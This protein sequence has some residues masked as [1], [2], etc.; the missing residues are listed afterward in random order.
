M[1]DRKSIYGW[2]LLLA[3]VTAGCTTPVP[4]PPSPTAEQLKTQAEIRNI[5]ASLDRIEKKLTPTKSMTVSQPGQFREH[6][7]DRA[8][9][10]KI[11]L[12]SNPTREDCKKYIRAIIAAT[13]DQNSFS[14]EDPQVKMLQ[15]VGA[16]NIDLLFAELSGPMNF[17]LIYTINKLADPSSKKLV[18]KYFPQ[19]RELVEAVERNGWAKDAK[20]ILLSGL[21]ANEG[22]V[23]PSW[24]KALA[25]LKDPTTYPTMIRFMKT[26]PN[27]AY[28]TYLTIS[29]LPGIKIED[30]DIKTTWRNL[31]ITGQ[32]WAL[33][34]FAPVAMSIGELEALDMV[35]K[36]ITKGNA[37]GEQLEMIYNCTEYQGMP[38][39]I[40]A[41][42]DQEKKRLYWDA[43]EKKFKA[44]PRQ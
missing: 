31:K 43:A 11:V 34:Q 7:A 30:A 8:V 42:Y 32:P 13:E 9:L 1:N 28:D 3:L 26:N 35:M 10:A 21:Y 15:Q 19:Y 40:Q 12:P 37:S 25:S 17:H 6:K 20:P 14:P 24:I 33:A 38:Q 36:N 41:Q 23:P 22:Y 27:N 4:Q 2:S 39:E 5:N 16:K 44:K 29:K 18:L